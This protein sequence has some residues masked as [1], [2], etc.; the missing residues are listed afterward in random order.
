MIISWNVRGL[1]KL[2][3]I[4]EV[5]FCLLNL[6]SKIS[7]PRPIACCSTLYKIISKILA[8][9]M[10]NVLN[11]VVGQNQA[12]FV[13]RRN[14][15]NHILLAYELINGYDKKGGTPRCLMQMDIQKENDTIEWKALEAILNEVGFPQRFTKWIMAAV[16]S[17]SYIFNVNGHQS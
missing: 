1:N 7:I 15:H 6:N 4:R 12:A 13:K 5:S 10:R 17:I 8:N 14:I 11:Q 9:R 2:G 16:S 3:K